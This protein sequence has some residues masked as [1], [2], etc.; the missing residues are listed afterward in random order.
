MTEH[1]APRASTVR[2]RLPAGLLL[3]LALALAVRAL[4]W[5]QARDLTLF[6]EPTGDAATYVQIADA[7]RTDGL[8]APAGAPYERPP[9][10][11]FFLRLLSGLGLGLP[12]VRA[13]QFLL[14]V[15]GVGLLWILGGRLAG[16]TGA[17]VAALGGAVYG[18]FIFFEAEF[19]S[20][21]IVVFLLEAALVLWGRRREALAAGAL[22]GL[23][24]LAQPNFLAAGALAALVSLLWPRPL[25]W[26]S[27][28]A[29]ILLAAGLC[30]PPLATLSR[31]GVV[32]GEPILISTNGGINFFIGNHPAA[33]GT[34]RIPPDSGL[35][36][37]AEG[38]F[39][40]AREVAE[41]AHG[42]PLSAIEVDRY[43]WGRGLDTWATDFPRA[44]GL[45]LGKA[46]LAVN[47]AEIPSHY[48][49]AYFKEHV[50]VLRFLP[51]MGLLFPFGALGL[52][53]AWRRGTIHPGV[54]FLAFL[55][56]VIPFFIT[57]RYRLPEAV[58]LWPAAG[59]AVHTLWSLRRT[60]RPF[61]PLAVLA[62]SVGVYA[63]LA[64]FPLYEGGT[65]RVHMLSMEGMTLLQG[66]DLA[67]ARAVL[68]R[69]VAAD[70]ANPEALG[71][72]AA[73]CE[74][75]GDTDGAA[76][77]YR[78]ALAASPQ[79]TEA[80]LGLEGIYRRAGRNAE[81]LEALDRFVLARGGRIADRAADIGVRR[82]LNVLSLGD[83]TRAE[84]LLRE[85]VA[86]DSTLVEG[87][88]GL[89][90]L[91]GAQHR[92]G[93]ALAAAERTVALA[94]GS[95]QIQMAYG[96]VLETAGR[97]KEAA[98]A[99]SKAL[100]LGPP[101]P[102]LSYRLGRVLAR[103]GHPEQAEAHLLSANQGGPFPPALWELG[104]VYESL[105]RLEDAATTYKALVRLRAPQAD[106]AGRRLARVIATLRERGR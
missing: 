40:S 76:T 29:A 67:G 89:T 60:R 56:S 36:D 81:A 28:R 7:L 84:G 55:V 86:A 23:C 6:R 94:P 38:L 88:M 63:V 71:T 57:A 106:A 17:V 83:T 92:T 47:G 82:G 58:F 39:I 46:V 52:G 105:G 101:N 16:R 79:A 44:F 103:L 45:T 49:Y 5:I 77:Y 97:P 33:D 64:N 27:R 9:L 42:R 53:L 66:G 13:I 19:L 31:N 11:P 75:E 70:P 20:I 18:P 37:R 74:L 34:F 8:L 41:G 1:S 69:A 26:P 90:F 10:Y 95:P 51:A 78:R 102:E 104:Q 98:V 61:A 72:M 87:W 21:S 80:Y 85:A 65:A 62:G 100:R 2:R 50:P 68:E 14:G 30:L 96:D 93:E 4:F 91:Y 3:I 99:Y 25:G 12:A 15:G 73:L 24:A 22:L 48:D 59:L 54:L 35:I 32:S 43:W